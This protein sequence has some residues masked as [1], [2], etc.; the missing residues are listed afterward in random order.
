MQRLFINAAILT[1]CA[2]Y[3]SGCLLAVGAVGGAGGVVYYKGNL[4]EHLNYSVTDIYDA[5]IQSAA[6]Q[7][8]QVLN[9]EHDPYKAQ[10]KFK[11]AD[12][13][14]IWVDTEAATRETSLIKIRVGVGGDKAKASLLLEKIKSRLFL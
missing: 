1:M 2:L 14:K 10:M 7:G 12:D 8:F 13:K 3:T 6:D 5:T 9:D 4:K 11:D